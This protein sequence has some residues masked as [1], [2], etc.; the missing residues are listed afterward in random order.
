MGKTWE[1]I[2]PEY[3]KQQTKMIENIFKETNI[4]SVKKFNVQWEKFLTASSDDQLQ[5]IKK[6]SKNLIRHGNK[7]KCN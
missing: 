7:E 1:E 3:I 4:E 5:R 2:G 6:P